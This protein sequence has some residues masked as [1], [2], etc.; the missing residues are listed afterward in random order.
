MLVLAVV[1]DDTWPNAVVDS[2]VGALLN[3]TLGADSVE[4]TITSFIKGV[5]GNGVSV[6]F[7]WASSVLEPLLLLATVVDVTWPAATWANHAQKLP[8]FLL[9]AAVPSSSSSSLPLLLNW[10]IP[11]AFMKHFSDI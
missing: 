6:S 1:V 3:D 5:D 9:N 8:Y 11:T 4:A 7:V 10:A 2:V